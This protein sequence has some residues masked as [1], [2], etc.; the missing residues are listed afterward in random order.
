MAQLL[1]PKFRT[2]IA[3]RVGSWPQRGAINY[4]WPAFA[5]AAADYFDMIVAKTIG[6]D[7][8]PDADPINSGTG[9]TDG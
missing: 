8:E 1:P 3:E 7:H 2:Y 4:D 9:S 5:E 6:E